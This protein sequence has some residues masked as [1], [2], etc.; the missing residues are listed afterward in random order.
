MKQMNRKK[1][2]YVG[3]IVLGLFLTFFF[4]KV[5]DKETGKNKRVIVPNGIEY[6]KK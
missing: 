2:L 3:V 1:I 5:V 6:F 4:G